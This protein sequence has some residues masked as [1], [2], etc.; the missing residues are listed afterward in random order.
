M[1]NDFGCPFGFMFGFFSFG[2]IGI[3]MLASCKLAWAN[4]GFLF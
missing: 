3:A 2:Y 1:I 4:M